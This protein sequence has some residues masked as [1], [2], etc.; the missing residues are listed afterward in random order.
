MLPGI[1]SLA[2]AYIVALLV[3]S[4]GMIGPPLTPEGIDFGNA[5]FELIIMAVIF[6]V[7]FAI[8][9]RLMKT[10][11]HPGKGSESDPSWTQLLVTQNDKSEKER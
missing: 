5:V 1:L 4:T 11:K 7:S 6:I 3:Q 10:K 9:D 8:L 2:I